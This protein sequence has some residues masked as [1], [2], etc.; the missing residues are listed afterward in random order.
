MSKAFLSYQVIRNNAIKLAHQI[1][2]EG[3]IPDVIYVR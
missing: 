3:F 2:N 1:H